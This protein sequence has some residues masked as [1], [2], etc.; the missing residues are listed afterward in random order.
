M[1]MRSDPRG[2]LMRPR[3]LVVALA[4]LLA[5]AVCQAEPFSF[6]LV[7]L[8]EGAPVSGVEVKL[9]DRA[10]GQTN[11]D[12]ALRFSGDP[13]EADLT[14][15]LAGA[16]LA[17][18]PMQL[19][20]GER[21]QLIAS[22][23][24]DRPYEL[25]FESSLGAGAAVVQAPVEALGSGRVEGRIVSA[26][27]GKPI[28]GAVLYV[29]G[30]PIEV[31]TDG[32]GRY[33][34]DAP[35]GSYALSVI[36]TGFASIT[37]DG[38]AVA[39]DQTAQRDL[40]LVPAGVELPEYVVLE[41]FVEG[42]L[43]A[44]TEERRESSAVSD[45]LGAEQIS[46]AGDS[47]AAGALR[48]VTGITLVDGKFVYVRGLGE[49]YSSTLLNGAQIPS[50][51][52]TRRV[53]PLD[54]FPTE[55]LE[56]IVIQKTYSAE[57][58]G[59]F[60]G[61]T[62]QLRT[63]GFP[64]SFTWKLSIGSGYEDGTTYSD[65]LRYRGGD[66]DWTGYDDGQ[67]ALPPSLVDATA[68]GTVL[69]P[70]TPFNPSGLTPQE[71]EALGEDL[72]TVG[73]D[74]FDSQIMP[75]TGFTGSIGNSWQIEDGPKFG[76]LAA[77]RYS[78]GWDTREEL[79][80]SYS[81]TEDDLTIAV[82]R[83]R[84]QTARTIEA[85]GFLN[86]GIEFGDDHKLKTTSI[87]LRQ[88]EDETQQNFGFEDDPTQLSQITQLEWL[89]NELVTHQVE[90]EHVIGP[91]AGL[92]VNWRYTNAKAGRDSPNTRE[93]RYD[94]VG[95]QLAFSARSDSN[96][97][98]FEVLEDRLK[99]YFLSLAK[100]FTL[101][102]DLA[103]RASAGFDRV[104][105][106][107]ESGI[108]RFLFGAVGPD[109][110]A[111]DPSRLLPLGQILVP[112]RIGTN[113]YQLLQIPR[114]TDNYNA[115]QVLDAAFLSLDLNWKD[116]WRVALGA[117]LESNEQ[118]V[119]TFA[120]GASAAPPVVSELAGDDLLP[121]LTV[122]WLRS[123][124]DQFRFGFSKTIAR[125]DFREL[126][127]SPF[128]DPLTDAE[129]FGNPDLVAAEIENYD[130]RWEY[131]FSPTESFSVALFLKDFTSPIETIQVPAT[132]TLQSFDNAETAQNFGVEF[133]LYKTLGFLD[134][135]GFVK[136]SFI[137]RAP[138]EH[139]YV[140]A[141]YAWIES[142]VEL[143]ESGA[144]QT[145]R[146]RPLQGQSPYVVN[147]QLGYEKPDG[148][149]TWGLLFNTFGERISRVGIFGQPDVYEQPFNQLDF[150]Y[151]WKFADGWALKTRFRNLLDPE[152]EFL[153]GED[154]PTRSYTK[155]REFA[156]SVE[157]K[158]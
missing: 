115:E 102:A 48:R 56:G 53:V 60:G 18:V 40:E 12:G 117:R 3:A 13:V 114:T 85:G 39:A 126:S 43:A 41:P 144:V 116:K 121:A 148:K 28:G 71:L 89:E 84:D 77:L 112:E 133:D 129:T 59:E 33:G 151:G 92:E 69:T 125:P 158:G 25:D 145:S 22:A 150:V 149:M 76:F 1:R 140:S 6:E 153:Q 98:R 108:Q 80:R 17:K 119:S 118:S 15:T 155:G 96:L 16:E 57:M 26:E 131:Y 97:I 27:N 49:R 90:G 147:L 66:S 68:G 30:T 154:F 37:V 106:E 141:N 136:N 10:L 20:S 127:E 11:A 42:S 88:T 86:L 62:I 65:G 46:R 82:E 45:V 94:Q 29:S 23:E 99:G 5:S 124:N 70:R 104:E 58:P 146:S 93:Y 72:A 4:L 132:G 103:L 75:P 34:F 138:W 74:V 54:L 21:L 55:I 79:R 50:P 67:R 152:V 142:S 109:A 81:G 63:K 111:G 24:A 134:D 87:I 14:L 51:D 157:W 19:R 128:T 7:V 64:E 31:K 135:F 130:F 122:T 9:G 107:R 78:Q 105:R 47:D 52:P 8:R 137:G 83:T 2:P 73:Y 143:G 110:N 32:D 38:V 123:Q 35:E 44:F 36:A 139:I 95:D 61:G 156:V 100:D 113:G 101:P 91:L 120:V